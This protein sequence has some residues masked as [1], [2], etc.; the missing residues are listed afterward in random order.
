MDMHRTLTRI[1]LIAIFLLAGMTLFSRSSKHEYS[2]YSPTISADGRT[3]IYQADIDEPK[4]YKIYA[5]QKVFDKWSRP[6]ALDS[7][8]SRICRRR[9]LHHL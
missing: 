4:K 1:A 3:M 5:K 2:E 9:V 7:I 6:V 8:N